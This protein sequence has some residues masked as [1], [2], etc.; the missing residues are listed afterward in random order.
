METQ[1]RAPLPPL[2]LKQA[3]RHV[4]KDPGFLT[5]EPRGSR[6]LGG[7]EPEGPSETASSPGEAEARR[8][9]RLALKPRGARWPFRSPGT[10][11]QA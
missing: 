6:S 2:P 8:M 9:S 5:P 10:P 1:M 7:C 3:Q 4:P 11:T